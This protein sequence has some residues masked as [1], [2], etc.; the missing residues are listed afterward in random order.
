MAEPELLALIVDVAREKKLLGT[1]I[2]TEIADC[3]LRIEI[4]NPPASDTSSS[5]S[6]NPPDS[7]TLPYPCEI[8]SLPD[9]L[10]TT[11]SR[12]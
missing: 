10:P 3:G 2:S 9:S 4:R 1:S 8:C 11:T 6:P 7:W 5:P 12:Q